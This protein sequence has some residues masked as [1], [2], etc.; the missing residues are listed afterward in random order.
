[1]AAS[2]K[3]LW[4]LLIDKDMK[5]Q[6]LAKVAHISNYT[7]S[8]LAKGENVTTDILGRICQALDCNIDD[9]MEFVE[10]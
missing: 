3:K 8:K 2:Y 10:Q 7:I 9:I 4:K 5:K 1:M 6:D